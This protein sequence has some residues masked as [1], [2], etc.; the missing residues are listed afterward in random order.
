[1]AH[2]LMRLVRN[3]GRLGRHEARVVALSELEVEEAVRERLYGRRA[4]LAITPVS[5]G[6]KV[7]GP[8]SS[9]G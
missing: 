8:A 6:A 4:G 2:T 3:A 7:A 5:Q 9:H 1:M